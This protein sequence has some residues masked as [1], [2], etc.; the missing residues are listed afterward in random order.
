[1]HDLHVGDATRDDAPA[2]AVLLCEAGLSPWDS[3]DPDRAFEQWDRLKAQLPTARVLVARRCDGTILA[4][5]TLVLLPLLGEGGAPSAVVEDFAVLP[6]M[7]RNGYGR[8]LMN[9]AMAIA[10]KAGCYKL[11]LSSHVEREA[12]HAFYERL[13]FERHGVSFVA[14]LVARPQAAEAEVG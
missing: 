9:E 3:F 1:M 7:Q 12:A 6:M 4:T 13:G 10:R 5:L 14:A 2:L 11:A 8:Q